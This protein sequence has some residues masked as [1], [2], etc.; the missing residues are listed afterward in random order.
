MGGCD[1]SRSLNLRENMMRRGG[2]TLRR[3][4]SSTAGTVRDE[5]GDPTFARE[6]TLGGGVDRTN[7]DRQRF[8]AM[9][10]SLVKRRLASETTGDGILDLGCGSGL[11]A[12]AVLDA[13]PGLQRLVGVDGSQAMLDL[14]KEVCPELTTAFVNFDDPALS[15]E[16]AE[17]LN[18][19]F[20]AVIS[21]QVLHELPFET[22]HNA[23]KLAR[24]VLTTGGCFYVQDRFFKPVLPGGPADD[25]HALWDVLT[26][27]R[28][29]C[30]DWPDYAKYIT[31]K[32][33]D[34][35]TEDACLALLSDHFDHVEVLYRVFNRSLIVA[36]VD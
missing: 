20:K 11:S 28:P 24:S 25:Y 3:S 13:N 21:S 23:V 16:A 2:L 12:K 14:T 17:L 5:W 6:W 26:Q 19:P 18:G 35:T 15:P 9:L 32:L 7:P 1:S 8:Q 34:A 27:D 30:L 31:E 36:R 10:G 4:W 29:D 22:K 33:D